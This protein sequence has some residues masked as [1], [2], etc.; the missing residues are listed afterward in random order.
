MEALNLRSSEI[1]QAE[2]QVLPV[3]VPL[4]AISL[5]TQVRTTVD[6]A[7]DL[8]PS[9]RAQGQQTPGLPSATRRKRSNTSK[10]SMSFG[11]VV[12]S[13]QVFRS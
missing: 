5:L 1:R 2:Y 11:E 3:A 6:V 8:V 4:K 12:T 9:I 7:D 10:R 13:W